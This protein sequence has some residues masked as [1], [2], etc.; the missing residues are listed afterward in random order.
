M[1]S[2]L[3]IF[4]MR[5]FTR[6]QAVGLGSV[7]LTSSL[8]GCFIGARTNHIDVEVRND[9]S[10]Q[11]IVTIILSGDFQPKAR[12]ETLIPD[13]TRTIEDFIPLLDYNHTFSMDVVLDDEVVSTTRY[14]INDISSDD[15]PVIITINGS[16]EISLD[17]PM[18]EQ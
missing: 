3:Q 16:G 1:H 13:G 17:I 18:A 10:E 7:A 11:H 15:G 6:R 14:E 12:A 2:E 8:A 4:A 5:D 9:H